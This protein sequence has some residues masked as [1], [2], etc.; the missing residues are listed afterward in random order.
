MAGNVS[1]LT[2]YDCCLS[3]VV[4]STLSSKPNVIRTSLLAT[5]VSQPLTQSQWE[6]ELYHWKSFLK[7]ILTN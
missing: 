3:Q 4:C 7:N 6:K 5:V 1:V 2:G